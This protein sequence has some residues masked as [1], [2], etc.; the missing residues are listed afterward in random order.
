M[1]I[2][3]QPLP[4]Q[5]GLVLVVGVLSISS[6]AILIRL[7][8][9][10]A[11]VSGVGF[12]LFLSASRLTVASLLLLPAWRHLQ[13]TQLSPGA[14]GYAVGAGVCLA[15]HIA[16]WITSLSFTSIAAST[17]LITTNPI[18]VAIIT[19]LWYR[20]KPTRLTV[21]GIGIAFAGGILIATGDAG[22]GSAGSN[23]SLGN[24]LALVG[25]W[26]VSLYLLLGR[27]A[28]RR[29]LGIGSYVAVAYTTGALVLLPL[30]LLV[31]TSY[32][33]YPIPVYLYILLIAIASQLIG[34]TS[35]NWAVRWIS[36][37]LVTLAILLEP[38]SSSFLGYLIFQEV[39]G[40]WILVGAVIVLVGVALAVCGATIATLNR[41]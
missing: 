23:P 13:A 26:M 16:A 36:P 24:L 2:F 19:W 5:V 4:W 33:D 34:H 39:P 41:M 1:R 14:L 18:W 29:G 32:L 27:E 35:L 20:E 12:S 17:T 6:T 21:L 30:P 15:L 40:L 37:T 22:T 10:S 3:K 25:A 38:I 9:A 31:G 28:Q 7:A 11:N 8:I